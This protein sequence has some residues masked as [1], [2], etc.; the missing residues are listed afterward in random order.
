MLPIKKNP[1]FEISRNSSL[2]FAI[3]LNLMLFFSWQ[4]LEYKTYERSDID[5]DVLTMEA[6]S[7]EDIPLINYN[8]PP[9]P[10]PPAHFPPPPPPPPPATM[11]TSVSEVTPGGT[12]QVHPA[13]TV[14][15]S[16]NVLPA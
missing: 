16:T 7:E 8:A 3:G 10:P 2:Y 6:Q 15:N 1:E 9:A 12:V 11:S 4:A 13:V 5:I 14:V